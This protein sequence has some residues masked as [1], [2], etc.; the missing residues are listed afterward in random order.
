MHICIGILAIRLYIQFACSIA[1]SD[2]ATLF[3]YSLACMT[4]TAWASLLPNGS[5]AP[6]NFYRQR[7]N[8]VSPA[9]A[10]LHYACRT[11]LFSFRRPL[12]GEAFANISIL[13]L[14]ICRTR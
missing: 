2:P 11:I 4:S 8:T 1:Q 7:E 14:P 12:F 9:L 5:S 13:C 10:T 6:L 3:V